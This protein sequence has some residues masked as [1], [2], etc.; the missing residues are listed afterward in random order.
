MCTYYAGLSLGSFP[1]AISQSG[2]CLGRHLGQT[3]GNALVTRL[4]I[5][6]RQ[7]SALRTTSITSHTSGGFWG[8]SSNH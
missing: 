8:W 4:Y 6:S 2:L 1:R 3:R 7:S 5:L